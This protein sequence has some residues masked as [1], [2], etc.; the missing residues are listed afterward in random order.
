MHGDVFWKEMFLIFSFL[1]SVNPS[2]TESNF[3]IRAVFKPKSDC[4]QGFLSSLHQA[5]KYRQL[6]LE[7]KNNL[8]HHPLLS[9]FRLGSVWSS[10]GIKGIPCGRT[11]PLNGPWTSMVLSG[12]KGSGK[13]SPVKL[14]IGRGSNKT[15]IQSLKNANKT[16]PGTKHSFQKMSLSYKVNFL[17]QL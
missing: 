7:L 4:L 5:L 12:G 1:S 9:N 16:K 11:G 13:D 14:Q 17:N 15:S 3:E 8:L 10:A 6:Y 2:N